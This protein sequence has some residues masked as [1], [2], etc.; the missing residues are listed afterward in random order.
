MRMLKKMIILAAILLPFCTNIMAEE[1]AELH[2]IGENEPV[3]VVFYPFREAILASRIDG[4]V[5]ENQLQPGQRV[6]SGEILIQL[7][8]V[9]FRIEMERVQALEKEAEATHEFAK[10][11]L[12]VQEEMLK[13]ELLN[14]IDYK[15]AQLDVETSAARLLAIKANLKEAQNQ[16][17]YCLVKAP[18]SG[19][20]LEIVTRSFET[21]RAGQPLI[22]IIDDNQLRAVMFIPVVLL[23]KLPLGTEIEVK[24]TQLDKKFKGKII[25][26]AP[27]ADHRSETIEIHALIDNSDSAITAGMTGEFDYAPYR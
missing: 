25:E 16:L 7:D 19:R 15:K 3:K 17:S 22:H 8:D 4:V 26:I 12:K 2:D 18:F 20:I 9:R 27:K 11:T 13:K 21:L 5:L 24:C 6:Q 10:Q 23:N 1:V 14:E